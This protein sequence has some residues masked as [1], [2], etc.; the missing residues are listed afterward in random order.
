M[1]NTEFE[2]VLAEISSGKHRGQYLLYARRST[3]DI[4]SQKNSI[5]YQKAETARF[6]RAQQMPIAAVTLPGFC[7]DGV[8][9]E[10]HSGF[11]EIA[12]LQF[13]ENNTVQYRVERPK[14][15]R[16]AEF[17]AKGY[18]KGVVFLCWDRASR[19]KGDDTILRKLMKSGVDIR[20]VLAQYDKGSAGELHM[21]IDGMF[22]EHHS[23][24]T[25]EKVTD[26]IRKKRD[27][28]YCT[29]KAP[30]GYLNQGVMER[31]PFDPERAPVIRRLFELADTTD[32]SLSDLRR[33][34]IEQ[35]FTMPPSLRR[36]TRSQM[37]QDEEND[38]R[39]DTVKVAHLPTLSTTHFILTNPFYTGQ[40]IGN[41]GAWV[42]SRSHDALISTELFDRVQAKL[43]RRRTSVH[44]LKKLDYPL[45]GLV[46]CACRRT[47]T[48]YEQ[49]G[50]LYYGARCDRACPNERKSVNL[51]FVR[52]MIGDLL[53]RLVLTEQEHA[54][55]DAS[56]ASEAATAE[57]ERALER[58]TRE[59]RARKLREDLT[60][61]ADNR[62]TLLRTGA[63]VPEA[64]A[65]EEARIV[66][67]LAAMDSDEQ[68]STTEKQASAA[69]AWKLSELLKAAK[70]CVENAEPFE[71]EAIARRVFSELVVFGNTLD[72]KA[73]S[74]FD[75]LERRFLSSCALSTWLSELPHRQAEMGAA[76]EELALTLQALHHPPQRP[77]SP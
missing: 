3:D 39:A 10:R 4:D 30:V 28:G 12:E 74:G 76:A 15:H 14:F 7:T 44:H 41:G 40:V 19:N 29:H 66:M 38:E 70:L 75:A 1:S 56:L 63:Y 32:W 59:R 69:A 64:L 72:L 60:Y 57:T 58:E 16:L 54:R 2:R 26:T 45:R 18:F 55:I 67:A 9:S 65:A 20:F 17:L 35:G 49:K 37:L 52:A 61:L 34:L 48:P 6:A 46:R 13:G 68:P 47:Y 53:D 22:A 51:A 5:Q 23:R 27:E 71:L 36:R 73:R 42:A 11:K 25:R 62:L 8:I 31:K 24:V 21:D 43:A 50:H 33:W 77:P